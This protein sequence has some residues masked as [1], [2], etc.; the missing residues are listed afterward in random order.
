MQRWVPIQH[1]FRRIVRPAA[2]H[3]APGGAAQPAMQVYEAGQRGPATGILRARRAACEKCVL[4]IHVASEA[5]AHYQ[6]DGHQ[7]D[8][9]AEVIICV[10]NSMYFKFI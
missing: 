3:A 4:Q 2:L 10:H 7:Y 1:V 9:R 6:R 5:L 8:P